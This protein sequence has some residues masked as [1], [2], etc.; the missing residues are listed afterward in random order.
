MGII[1]IISDRKNITLN[2]DV[3]LYIIMNGK[4]AE[5]HI[6][7]GR[8]YETRVT[9]KNLEGLLKEEFVKIHRGCIVS[10][11]AIHDVTDTVDLSN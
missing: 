6:V 8:V 2:S 1:N 7:G 3:I 4:I 11:K 9:L 10:V 5:I